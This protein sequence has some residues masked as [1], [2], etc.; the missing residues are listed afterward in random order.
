MF[1]RTRQTVLVIWRQRISLSSVWKQGNYSTSW[2]YCSLPSEIERLQ[3]RPTTTSKYMALPKRIG[4]GVIM[5]HIAIIE[6]IYLSGAVQWHTAID[7]I[8]QNIE[9]DWRLNGEM[10][11]QLSN[12]IDQH[13][14]VRIVP[15]FLCF[16]FFGFAS[17]LLWYFFWIDRWICYAVDTTN[18]YQPTPAVLEL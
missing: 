6:S 17:C 2:H 3:K 14:S 5:E 8:F 7:P 11:N 10:L 1:G 16:L 18:P 12:G 9:N 13:N 4:I 15:F